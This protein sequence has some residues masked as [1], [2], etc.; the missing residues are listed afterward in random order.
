MEQILAQITQVGDE[1][2]RSEI[3]D[4]LIILGMRKKRLNNTRSLLVC[5]FKKM[6]IKVTVLISHS[7]QL[8]TKFC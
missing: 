7:Y 6:V 4:L 1:R 5:L 8:R 3:R 2:T